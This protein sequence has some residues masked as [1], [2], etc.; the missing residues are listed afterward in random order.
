MVV[1]SWARGLTRASEPRGFIGAGHRSAAGGS[2]DPGSPGMAQERLSHGSGGDELALGC[3]V[4][5]DHRLVCGFLGEEPIGRSEL[6]LPPPLITNRGVENAFREGGCSGPSGL[7][8]HKSGSDPEFVRSR[9]V[10]QSVE[11]GIDW[12]NG[13]L[14]RKWSGMSALAAIAGLLR[15]TNPEQTDDHWKHKGAVTWYGWT[16]AW[17]GPEGVQVWTGHPSKGAHV[18][19][20]GAV[21]RHFG[22][23]I[24]LTLICEF[25]R[26][27]RLDIRLDDFVY[28][29]MPVQLLERWFS[30]GPGIVSHA[31][32]AGPIGKARRGETPAYTW[33]L[34]AKSSDR[35]LRVYDKGVESG[36]VVDAV[37]WELQCRRRAADT[38]RSELVA[39]YRSGQ[40]VAA[41]IGGL[42]RGF[43]DF[44]EP[45]GERGWDR[46]E[47]SER[48]QPES[49]WQEITC[50]AV[51]GIKL[52]KA[53][54][55]DSE[56]FH[57][58]ETWAKQALPTLMAYKKRI[59]PRA[60]KEL[61]LGGDDP[62]KWSAKQRRIAGISGAWEALQQECVDWQQDV[63]CMAIE[64]RKGVQPPV[65]G[66]DTW[67]RVKVLQ[68]KQIK[69]QNGVVRDTELGLDMAWLEPRVGD[70]DR[71]FGVVKPWLSKAGLRWDEL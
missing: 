11:A 3:S 40:D 37:R 69:Q 15:L 67:D 13:T 22:S 35:R 14:P 36:G 48:W 55:T 9:S 33:E 17:E 20:K 10:E 12:V 54:L 50:G 66:E 53:E 42:F 26:C 5:S 63:G 60:Y 71:L 8:G 19:V 46:E 41:V 32:A 16:S 6:G 24:L 29:M 30:G 4:P 47:H 68:K 64:L 44:R 2:R 39:A 34:G 45:V 70:T 52:A 25:V 49:W 43:V 27:S 57:R 23:D 51:A 18:Q 65:G 61:E 58:T 31:W 38:V 1:R 28:R 59:G 62:W 7:R 21:C 56:E